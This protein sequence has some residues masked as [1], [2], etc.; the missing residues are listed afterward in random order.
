MISNPYNR[1]RIITDPSQYVYTAE[2]GRR[3]GALGCGRC[4]TRRDF[5]NLLNTDPERLQN[6]TWGENCERVFLILVSAVNRIIKIL[7]KKY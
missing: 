5:S 1:G 6:T 7:G 2:G 3:P 4:G